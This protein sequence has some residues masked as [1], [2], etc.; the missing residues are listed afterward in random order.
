MV[1]LAAEPLSSESWA[2]FG[3]LPREDTDPDDGAETLHF[4]WGDAHVNVIAHAPDEVERT[5]AGLVCAGL[6]RHVTHTQVLMPRNCDAVVAVAPPG[7]DFAKDGTGALRAF[8][9]APLDVFV[10]ARGTWHWGPMPL[11]DDAVRI[12]NVQGRRY[13]QDNEYADLAQLAG[14]LVEVTSP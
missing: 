1:T 7:H 3:W 6:Y 4:E 5:A 2:P 13:A 14:T 11:G 10:L 12:L 8:R 9:V